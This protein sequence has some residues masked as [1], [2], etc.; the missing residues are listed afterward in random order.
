MF[1]QRGNVVF[2]GPRNELLPHLALAGYICPPLY[3]PSDYCM[4]LISVDVR[5]Q[6][7][8]RETSARIDSLV[9]HWQNC[10]RKLADVTAEKD[11]VSKDPV[12]LEERQEQTPIWIALPVVLDR[13]LRNTWRLQDVFWTRS[14]CHLPPA[15][16]RTDFVS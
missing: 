6:S 13:S 12:P 15:T 7:K 8:Q 2:Q 16:S 14:A 4:D 9:H 11:G 10:A 1:C 5:R 3:N